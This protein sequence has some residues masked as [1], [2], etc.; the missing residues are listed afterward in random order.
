M[1]I[2]LSKAGYVH[3]I[4]T[5]GMVD[6]PG[7]RYLVFFSG[8]ALRCKYCH[9]P[10]TWDLN[11]GRIM[12][13]REILRD[14]EKYKSYLKFSGGGVTFTGGDPLRQHDFLEALLA[15]CKAKGF[16]T[17]M[18]TSGY[19]ARDIVERLLT[20]T[21]LLLLDIKSINPETYKLVTGV[22]ID[23]S[24][25]TLDISRRMGVKTWVRYVLVPGLTD[26][27]DDI[28]KLAEY[29]KP[30]D[31][32][33]KVEVVPFHKAGEFKWRDLGQDY[34]LWDTPAPS[35]E[36]LVKAREILSR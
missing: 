6:G 24:L 29:L 20:Y 27:L 11:A 22:N 7:I 25:R 15:G 19:G 21:D 2:D 13:V 3:S 16:H 34:E 10:D 31:N 18:D 26:N 30:Y 12:T 36:L 1:N 32:V 14:I 17:A 8:C 4:D 23:R 9:N 33:E 5:C 28:Y 35:N